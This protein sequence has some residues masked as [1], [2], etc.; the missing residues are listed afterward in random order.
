[1]IDADA[2]RAALVA[3]AGAFDQIRE[4]TEGDQAALSSLAAAAREVR[5]SVADLARTVAEIA[6]R[7]ARLEE[8][9]PVAPATRLGAPFY[10][11]P[12]TATVKRWATLL[13]KGPSIG[14]AVFNP[15]TGPGAVINQAYVA[16]VAAIRAAGVPAAIYIPSGWFDLYGYGSTLRTPPDGIKRDPANVANILAEIDRGMGWYPSDAVFLDE[17]N[18]KTD[19]PA[20]F[21][22]AAKIRDHVR[23]KW[24][25]KVYWNPGTGFPESA[26]PLGDGF[27]RFE[28]DAAKYRA[29]APPAWHAK[30]L[31]QMW[32]CVYAVPLA[33]MAAVVDKAKQLKPALVWVT[34]DVEPNQYNAVPTYLDALCERLR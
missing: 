29:F 14:L 26:M 10:C 5:V 8:P 6:A 12:D 9:A 15:S 27:M 17:M 4:D 21:A 3:L 22:T 24:G 11:S 2:A 34:D 20:V 28:G 7:V 25:A 16:Q 13:A 23:S 33:D 31:P 19:D 30:Y 18:T 1:M 32:D